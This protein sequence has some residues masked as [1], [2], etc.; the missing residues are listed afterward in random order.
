MK[1]TTVILIAIGAVAALVAILA[2]A[3]ALTPRPKSTFEQLVG[4]AGPIASIFN[5]VKAVVHG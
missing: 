5:P 4:A 2:I 3:K 1:T